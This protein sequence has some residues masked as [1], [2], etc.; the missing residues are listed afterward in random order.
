[1]VKII[2]NIV[3]GKVD[4]V[5]CLEIYGGSRG[6]APLILN[7]SVHAGDW[8]VSRPSRFNSKIELP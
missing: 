6:I 3:A 1:M 2:I 7:L 4:P 5:H 8:S